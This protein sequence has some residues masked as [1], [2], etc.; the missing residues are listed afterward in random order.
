MLSK[1]LGVLLVGSAIAFA[2]G[3]ASETV[4]PGG[5]PPAPDG[6]DE[7]AQAAAEAAGAGGRSSLSGEL[8]ESFST[9]PEISRAADVIAVVRVD[10]S[11][12]ES[13]LQLPFTI[14]STTVDEPL[15]GAFAKG[16]TITIVETGGMHAGRSKD[17][18]GEFGEPREVGFEGVPVM[19]QGEAYLVFLQ[20]PAHIGPVPEGAY[21]ILGVVQGKTRVGEDGRLQFTGAPDS[22]EDQDMFAVPA[23]LAGR[24]LDDVL[25][26]IRSIAS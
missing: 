19:K 12:S 25:A 22:L 20:G 15:K 26:E 16:E 13:F 1:H 24:P 14:S 10:S 5:T 11:T 7:G 6:G 8:A 21:G 2:G 9:L 3:C 4:S 18:P 17:A 23:S